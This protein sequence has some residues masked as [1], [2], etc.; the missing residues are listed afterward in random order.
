MINSVMNRLQDFTF[1]SQLMANANMGCLHSSYKMFH[2][3][4]SFSIYL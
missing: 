4:Y 1:F 2:G 3:L